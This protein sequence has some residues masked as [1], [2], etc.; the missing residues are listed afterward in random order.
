MEYIVYIYVAF[1]AILLAA[2]GI[3]T[4]SKGLDFFL[5]LSL[6]L[7]SVIVRQNPHSDMI[8]YI[9]NMQLEPKYLLDN[10]YWIKNIVYWGSAS[11][12][13]SLG[14]PSFYVLVIFDFISFLLILA[15][16]KNKQLP[17]YIVPLF[18]VSFIGV[19]GFQNIYRQYL[20]TILLFYIYS[21]IS[22]KPIL[23]YILFIVACFIHNSSAIVIGALVIEH[24]NG[25]IS[26]PV[27]FLGILMMILISPYI[28]ATDYMYNTGENYNTLYLIVI[29]AIIAFIGITQM[30]KRLWTR[31]VRSNQIQ[32]PLYFA[33]IG[34]LSFFI[35]GTSLF[36]ERLILLILPFLI[37]LAVV[38]I[39]CYR[40]KRYMDILITIVFILPTFIFQATT[41]ML[42]NNP[43]L[44]YD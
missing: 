9:D 44:F 14:I 4:H 19:F 8:V 32:L 13:Y 34:I 15:F 17:Y 43:I 7:L 12:L 30:L 35:M 11:L 10:F 23:G 2:K 21:I 36:Y 33:I 37:V 24:R 18:Y 26:R 42:E 16:R 28:F 20:A 22:S 38:N 25:I 3:V 29:I 40:A 31:T 27:Y 6:V 39:H 41:M 5:L 1:L